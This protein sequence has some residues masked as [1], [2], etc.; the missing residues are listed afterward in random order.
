VSHGEQMLQVNGVEICVETFGEP[1][2]AAVLLCHG[3]SASMLWWPAELCERLAARARYVIR[4]DNR[5][6]GRS[7]AYPPG[8]PDYTMA[9]MADD[10][11]AVCDTLGVS[12][13]HLVGMSM[14]GGTVTIAAWR[15]P[16]R[17]ASLTLVS[18]TTG[19]G[20]LP[21]TAPEVSAFN[22]TSGPDPADR[23]AV[24][25]YIVEM[26]RVYTGD[27]PYYHRDAVRDLAERDVDRSRDVASVLVNHYRVRPGDIGDHDR[28]EITV[29]VLVVHGE[30]DP[31]FPIEHAHAL[32]AAFPGAQLLILTKAGH[33]LPEELWDVFVDALVAHTATT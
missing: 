27:S 6:T 18:T 14:A 7:T 31:L 5:D 3:A 11:I 22:R 15:H 13:A 10:A 16:D 12:K 24:V 28:A 19:D 17:V 8:E 21:P 32:R 20:G 2:D 26:M 23:D 30:M 33:E 4:Y 29:P 9:D 25:D 1:T